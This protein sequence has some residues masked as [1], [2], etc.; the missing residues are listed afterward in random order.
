MEKI[1]VGYI[2]LARASFDMDLAAE[3]RSQALAMLKE[4]N[5][6]EIVD[7]GQ[8]VTVEPEADKATKL[9]KDKNIDLLL[10]HFCTF[11]LG[12]L[13]PSM[14]VNLNVPVVLLSTPEPDFK[15]NR[16]RSNSFCALNLNCFTLKNLKKKHRYIFKSLDDES[17]KQ[18]FSV[19]FTAIQAIKSLEN[20]RVGLVGSRSPGFYTSNFNELGLLNALGV[21]VEHIDISKVY[22]GAEK[23]SEKEV[24]TQGLELL[25]SID[26]RTKV[27]SH[28]L[29]NMIRT[30]TSFANLAEEFRLDAFAVKCWPEFHADYG[31]PACAAIGMMNSKI[32]T[33]AEGDVYGAVTMMMQ[34]NITGEIPF[35]ADF[36]YSD[37][38]KN[39]GI[40][41]HCGCASMEL[42]GDK[43]EITLDNFPGKAK[44]A[45]DKGCVMNF[46][47]FA[48]NKRATVN[49]I[50][51]DCDGNFRILAITGKNEK[52]DRVIR[53]NHCQVKFDN[54]VESIRKGI[55]D[56]GFEHHYSL[57]LQD[58]SAVVEEIA[59]WKNFEL[60]RL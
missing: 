13:T 19:I 14:A 5:N 15:D 50:G 47:I 58:I 7:A 52:S 35:F 22:R 20:K 25:K 39:T 59:F 37:I 32:P 8:L 12:T 3:Y 43:S 34:R 56:N 54:T 55:L 30:R 28:H 29:H 24:N 17:I 18:D 2:S 42:A 46:Q 27:T 6:I 40:F 38:E 21:V 10:V 41:W 4:F 9:F 60:I 31:T 57:V 51:T 33:A 53:G 48:K 23:M 11:T 49:R 36:I 26:N 16:L 44:G 45:P 1:K